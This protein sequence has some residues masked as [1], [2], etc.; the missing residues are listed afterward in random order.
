MKVMEKDNHIFVACGFWNYKGG[1]YI[2]VFPLSIEVSK[3][4]K[5]VCQQ[6]QRAIF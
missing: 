1:R 4:D 2:Y 5:I 3:N 6:L